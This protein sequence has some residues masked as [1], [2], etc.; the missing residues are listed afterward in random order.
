MG[1]LE[2][3]L[4]HPFRD[5]GWGAKLILGGLLYVIAGALGFIPYVGSIFCLLISFIPLGYAYTVF[6]DRMQS[7]EGPLPPWGR[8]GD[9]F[10]QGFFL[11]LIGLG[12]FFIPGVLYWLGL[13]LWYDGGFSAFLGVLFLVLG[14]GIGLVAC[15]LWPMAVAF[16]AAQKEVLTAAFCW[17]GIIEK[18]WLVQRDYFIN[19]LASLVIMLALLYIYSRI[20][21]L[22]W[23][24]FA[25][26][27]FYVTL[28]FAALYGE[29]CRDGAKEKV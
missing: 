19:W 18:L 20:H 14:V 29:I 22:G 2:R 1:I 17:K 21:Y 24:L 4:K 26:G 8:W 12:Y 16:Y 27:L 13:Y 9:L 7:K 15:F 6:L 28:V 11:S 23:I 25:F 10:R 3:A 5:P